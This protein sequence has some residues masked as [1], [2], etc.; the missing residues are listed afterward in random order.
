MQ[1]IKTKIYQNKKNEQLT[2]IISKKKLLQMHP[3][4]ADD[5]KKHK[6]PRFAWIK[7]GDK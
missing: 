2:A 6:I 3:E 4:L 1:F 7:L 5:L